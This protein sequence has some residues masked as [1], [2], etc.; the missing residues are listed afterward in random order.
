MTASL[1]GVT[2]LFLVVWG[3]P[4]EYGMMI[5][6]IIGNAS[7]VALAGSPLAVVRDV[8]RDGTSIYLPI[9]ITTCAVINALSWLLY[10][11]VIKD[12]F[13]IVPNGLGLMVGLVQVCLLFAFPRHPAPSNVSAKMHAHAHA[14][15]HAHSHPSKPPSSVKST[16]ELVNFI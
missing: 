5:S 12:V 15:A 3:S 9:P 16:D 8:I 1:V 7:V 11:V 2:L 6:G 4:R 13:V 14:H 10:G